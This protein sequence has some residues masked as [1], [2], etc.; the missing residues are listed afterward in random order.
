ME[1]LNFLKGNPLEPTE[2]NVL[3]AV[4][5]LKDTTT[6][7]TQAKTGSKMKG[8]LPD[9]SIAHEQAQ[10]L[11]DG[12]YRTAAVNVYPLSDKAKQALYEVGYSEFAPETEK[13]NASIFDWFK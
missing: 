6:K 10:H 3:A 2:A 7:L 4:G 8:S 12:I 13:Q 11:V 9:L 1:L 5:A